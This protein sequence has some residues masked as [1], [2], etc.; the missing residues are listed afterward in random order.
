MKLIDRIYHIINPLKAAERDGLHLG[1]NVTLLS[2]MGSSF[3]SEPYLITI[4]D[5]V[6]MSGGGTFCN[7]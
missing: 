7:S 3:G 4:E 1:K 6:R 5:E 2:K